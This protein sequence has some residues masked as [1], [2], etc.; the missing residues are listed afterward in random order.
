M[1][2]SLSY[3]GNE[4]ELGG[5]MEFL[6]FCGEIGTKLDGEGNEEKYGMLFAVVDMTADDEVAVETIAEIKRQATAALKEVTNWTDGTKWILTQLA[7]MPVK[8]KGE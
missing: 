8:V 3:S 4:I 5:T 2:V 7:E 6:D 1:S